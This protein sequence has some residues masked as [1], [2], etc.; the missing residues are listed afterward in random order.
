MNQTSETNPNGLYRDLFILFL[1][2]ITSIVSIVGNVF[3]C[4]T[5]IRKK[6]LKSTTYKLIFSM[7]LS[8]IAG[9]VVIPAQWLLCSTLFLDYSSVNIILCMMMKTTQ[10]L[11]YYVSSLTMAAIAYDR[12]RLVCKPLSDPLK[13]RF[14]LIFVWCVGLIFI[15]GNYFTMKISEFFSPTKV[16]SSTPDPLIELSFFSLFPGHYHL[17]CCVSNKSWLRIPSSSVPISID[18]PILN[19]IRLDRNL[20]HN[21]DACD[22][23]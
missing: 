23:I 21:G 1:Y 3:V 5:I 10:M 9:G 12:Y 20:L 22:Q 18:H 17:S 19:S 13:A 14:M 6:N 7:S 16:S 4:A 2:L 11:S 15:G 8:D